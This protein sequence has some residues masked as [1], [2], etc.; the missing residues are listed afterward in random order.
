M[1]RVP[2]IAAAIVV[3]LLAAAP[4]GAY[5]V[6]LKDG[7]KVFGKEKYTVRKEFA[8]FTIENGNVAQIPLAKVD[9]P[10]TEKYNKDVA[11]NVLVLD[12][13]DAKVL[14]T[15][16]QTSTD[17]ENLSRY[18][19]QHES[20]PRAPRTNAKAAAA[21]KPEAKELSD[22]LLIREAIRILEGA[23]VTQYKLEA[24]PKV[25]LIA[26]Q[27]DAVFKG[28]SA[29]ARLAQDLTSIGKAP[30]LD[31]EIVSTS[32]SDGGRFRM[33]AENTKPLTDGAMTASE[34]FVQNVIF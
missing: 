34:F 16:K 5:V 8:V 24:G 9:V 17:R 3:A 33:T 18:I 13:P 32:G 20:Q 30:A 23:G 2:G 31:V 10:A 7:S 29:A 26:D 28:I 22:P 4:A 14:A 11:G 25:V 19:E 27:E 15:P 6:V 1:K 21:P 12:T